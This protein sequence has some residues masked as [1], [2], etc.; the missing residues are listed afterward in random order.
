MPQRAAASYSFSFAVL[1]VTKRRETEDFVVTRLAWPA[2]SPSGSRPERAD[3]RVATPISIWL[4][5]NATEGPPSGSPSNWEAP[6]RRRG[7]DGRRHSG[8]RLLAARAALRERASIFQGVVLHAVSIYGR[9][10]ACRGE[11]AVVRDESP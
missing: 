2:R 9:N 4:N 6:I 8:R 7:G 3:L 1:S 11:W 5:A 10:W